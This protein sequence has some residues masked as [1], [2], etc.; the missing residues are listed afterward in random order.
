MKPPVT[1]GSAT[2]YHGNCLDVLPTIG[3]VGHMI[4][5][6]PYESITQAAI[7]T[8]PKGNLRGV[9]NRLGRK[10]NF[11]PIDEIREQVV[12]LGEYCDGW[13]IAFCTPEGVGRWADAINLSP[14]K[15][16]RACVWVKPDS[17]P[18]FNGQCPASGAENFVVAWAGA[19][20]SR[21]NASGKRGV[22]TACVNNPERTGDHPT[23]K[24]RKLMTEILADFTSPGELVCD[25]FMG[26]GTT[27]VA[28]VRMGR[29][30]IGIEMDE[31]YFKLACKRIE[32]AQRQGS[33]FGEAA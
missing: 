22:Y 4:F 17:T 20:H 8:V 33:L 13:Y 26:S 21:W 11:A 18:Q 28:A 1:I 7:G 30:F 14:L 23:E 29:P 15:Y 27:G 16:K 2:L 32:D 24:P 6:P 9:S 12:A 10:L 3:R 19:G 25:L 31:T 5:D